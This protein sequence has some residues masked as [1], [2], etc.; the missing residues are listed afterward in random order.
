MR[1]ERANKLKNPRC[2]GVNCGDPNGEVRRCPIG[3][4]G[5]ILLCISCAAVENH[6]R[7][8]R[9]RETGQPENF[10]QMNWHQCAVYNVE[11]A[12]K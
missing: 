11:E 2:D 7:Y 8:L 6:E 5:Y 12:P 10:R 3:G 1:Y 9:G 4:G